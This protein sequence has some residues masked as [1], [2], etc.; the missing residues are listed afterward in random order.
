VGARVAPAGA[1]AAA[2]ARVAPAG[3]RTARAAQPRSVPNRKER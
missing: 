2:G 3:R 1:R